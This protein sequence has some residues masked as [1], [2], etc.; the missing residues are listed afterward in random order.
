[1]IRVARSGA[2]ALSRRALR[3]RSTTPSRATAFRLTRPSGS[4]PSRRPQPAARPARHRPHLPHHRLLRSVPPLGR[5]ARHAFLSL[6]PGLVRAATRSSTPARSTRLT[7]PSSGS[8]SSPRRCSRRCSCTSRSA[9]LRSGSR[10]LRRRWLLPVI[11]APGAGLLGLWVWSIATRE[12]TGLLLA[13]A[14]PDGHRLRR[15]SSTCWL[16]PLVPAQLPPRR[17]A[18]AAPA[19]E[20]GHPRNAAGGA[21]VHAVLREFL[22]CS[23]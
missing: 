17:H 8:T 23:T 6:L 22:S 13:P 16:P 14:Q 2:R 18:A 21:A 15:R 5:A 3:S 9:S 1:M 19:V 20:V 11:Y 10:T 4:F 12:A 7:G